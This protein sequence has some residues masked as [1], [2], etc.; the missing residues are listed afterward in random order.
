MQRLS[1]MPTQQPTLTNR[2]GEQTFGAACLIV[3]HGPAVVIGLR[4]NVR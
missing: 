2:Q 4:T 3:L 1:A